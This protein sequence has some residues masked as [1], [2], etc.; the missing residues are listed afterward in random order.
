MRKRVG[1]PQPEVIWI[2]NNGKVIEESRKM[3]IEKT[4]LNTVLTINGI[5]S[6]DQGEFALKIKNRCGEDKYAIGIQVTDRPAPPGKPAVEDQNLDSVRLRWAAPTNDGGSPVRNYTVEMCTE[7]SK[8]WTKA[9][10][11]KQ[12]FITLF[13]LV[14]GENY[15]FRV[16]ADN[17]FGQSEPSEESEIVYV[18]DNSRVL[19]EPKKKEV[20]V[21]EQ[22]SV[23]YQ[24]ISKEAGPSEY[25]TIDIHRLPNDLQAKYIIHEELGKGAYGTVYRATERATGKTWAAKMV[26]VRPGVKKENVI[27]E[28]SMMNQLHHEKLLNLHEAFDMGNEMWLIEEFVS[29]GELFEKIL[30]DDSLM[31]EEEVR[32]YMHQILLGVSHMHKNQIVHLDLKPENILLK[33]KNSTDLKIIDFG[34]ARKLD[35]KKSVKLLFG[36]PEFCA[37][38]VVNYQP[39]GLSTD[40][41]T[42]GV[43]SYVLLSGLSPFL[44][45]SDE[46][47]LANVSAADWDFDDPSWDDV[48]DLA[49][50]FIC[51]LMIKDKRKRM[52]VQDALRHPWITGPLLSAF[53]DLSEYVKKMQP[54]PDKSGIPARQKRNFLSLKRW[55][56]DLLPIGRLA[57]R[58]AIFRRL[59]MDG[60]FERNIAFDT[61]AAP[62]VKKQL[63]DIVANVGDLI[64]TLSCDVDGVPSPKVQWYKDDKEL[65]VPSMKYDSFYNEGLAEL[66]VKNIVESDAGKY[67]CR[68]TNDLGSIMTHAK[69]SVKSDDKKK[70]KSETSPAVIE[71]KKDRKTSKVVVV[72]EMIDMPP[73]FHH[74]LQDDEA[75]IGEP[76]V[77]VVT[78]TTLPEPTVEWYHNGEHI[79]IQDSNYLQKHDKGRYELHIL[80]VDSTDEG[81][82]K[83]VGKNAFGECESEG[84]L[85]VVVPDGQ[86]APSFGRQLSDVKCSESDIL[87]LEVN[88]KANPAPEIN[89]FRNEAE[90][91][92]SQRHRLQFDDGSGNYSLTIIDA[93][94]EDSGEYKCV[95]KNKIGKAHTVCCVRIEELLA[96][97]SKKIDG[98]KAPR[99]RMQLPTPREVPQGS[100]LTLVCSVSGTPHP[101]IRWTKDD[102]PIDM[103]NK[104]VRHENGV[105]TLH[106]IGARDEDQG[107]YVC[108]AENIHG[109]AQS[110]SV[111]EIKEAVDKDHIKPK[112]LEPLVNCSTCEGNEIV[113]ECCVTGKPI[114]AITWYKDGLKLIIENRMLQYTDRKGVSRLNIMNVVMDDAG[115]YTCEAVNTL[116]KD[117]THCTVK[118]VDMGLAKTRLTPVRSRSRS[119]SR[120]P[121]VLGG[122]I[123][124]PPVVTRPLADATVTEGNRELLEVEVDGFPTPTIEWYH[125]GKL[126]AESRTLRTYFDGRVA[127][128]KIYEAH[129]EHNGQYVCKVSNKLGAVET[130]ACVVVEGPHA[131]EHVTQMPTFVKK[132]QD[133]V[134]KSAGET[135][136][137][138]CQ[139]YANPAAQVVWLHNGKALQQTNGNYKTRLFDDNTATLVIENVTDELC[140]T[141]TAV[142]TNQFGDVH[143]SAQLTIT[144]SEARKVA[145]SLP[146]F[147]IEPKPKINVNEGATLSIQADLNGS[148]TPEVVWLKDNSELVESER[149]QI[150]CDGV[151]YQLVV[152]GVG[153]EDEGTYTITAENEKGKVRQNTE[154][155]VT[156]S[157]DV[158]EKKEKKKVEKKDEDKKKPGRPGLPRPSGA[159]KT[160]QVTIAFDAPSEGPADSYEVERRCPDQREWTK[161]GTSKSLELEVKSLTPNTEYIFRVA[162]RNK[163]GLGEWAEMMTT[164]KTAPSGQAPQFSILPQSKM[165]IS[166]D[167]ELEISVEFSGN[168]TPSVKWYKENVQVVPDDKINIA[169]TSTSSTLQSKSQ[170]ENGTYTCFIENELGQASASCQVT[171][172][173]REPSHQST[174]DH[175]LERNLV[176]VVQKQLNNESAQA[177]QQIMLTCRISSRSG[178]T[179]AWFN[180]DERIES[181]G[182]FE[183][184]SDK[185]SN[186]KLVCHAVQYNDAGKYRCVVTN[187]YGYAESE[188]NVT[189]EDITKFIAPSFSSTLSDST[190]ILG[191]NITL[192][193]KVEGFPTPEISWTK[194]GER[195][196][197]T[198]RIRQIQDEN[199]NCKLIISKAESDDTGVYVCS[200]TS[201]SGV[202]STSSMVMIAKTTGTDSH[203]VIAQSIDDKQEKPRFIRAPPSLIEVNESGQFTLVAKAIGEPKPTVTWLKDGR[204]ILRTNR[205]YHHFVTGDGESHLIAECVVSKTSGIFSCKAENPHGTVIA[206]TQVIVQKMKPASDLANVAPKFTIPLTDMGIVNGHPTTL[207]CNVTGSPE[208]TLEWIYIDDSGNKT[209]LTS[210]TTSWTECR[211]GKVAEL[212]SE[213]VL[214][215]Q[216]G[217]YQCVATNSSGK[218]TTQC[219]LLVGELSDEPAGPPRFVKCLQDTWTPLKESIEF[220]VELAGFPTPDLTWYHNE[221]KIIEGKDV[222][223]T[224][225]S[226]TTSVL[227]IKNVSLASLG[228][229]YVEASNIHGV[230]RNAGRLN[231]SDE[232]RK[233]EPPQ[234]KHVLEPVLAVQPK[235]AFSE[236]HP[237]A[238]SS[239][240]TA[241][242]K[243]GAAP[244][245]LQGLEDMDLK[246]GASAAVA[247]KLGRKL[248]PHRSTTNDAD[249]LAKALAQSLKLEEPRHLMESRLESA[250]NTALDEVRAAINSRNKRVCRPKFMVK[251]KPKKVL[252]EY[253]SLRL[254]TAIS[255]NPM[256]QVHWD[257][258]GIILET[259]NKYSIYNDGD[260]YYLEVHHVST[261]DKGFYNCTA[262]NNEGIITCT[263]EIDVLPNKADSAAQVAKRR[264]RKEAKAPNFIEVLPGRSQANLNEYLCVECSV[265]AY[266]C[267]SIIWTRNSVRLLP[268]ADRYTMS[269]DGECASLKFISVAPGDEGTYSCEAVNEHGTAVSNMNLL[270]SGMDPNAAEGIPPLFRFEKIKSVKK[271]VDGSRVELA[272]ELV[273]AS[274]PLQI[275]WLRNKVTIVDSPS[276]SYS[277]SEKMVFLTIADVFPEDGGEYTVEAKNQSGIAR[278]TMQLDVRSNERSIADEAPRVFDFE[279]TTRTD[280][281]TSVELRAKIIGHP[282]PVITWTKANQK[283]NNEE[284]YLMRNE[285]DT[286]IL[287]ISNVTRADAGKYVLTAINASGQ[288][289]AE[290]ELTVIQSTKTVGEKPKFNE[291]PISVQTCEKNRAELRASFSGTP[292]PTCRWFYSGNELIDGLDGYTISVSE[293]DSSLLINSVDKKHFGEYLCTIRNQNGEELAN[294]MI[295]SEGSSAALPQQR[296]IR[297]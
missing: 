14:P 147:I 281:G 142:A 229:Y 222:K 4:A 254:K 54:K 20:K 22:E 88:I 59:T 38:E 45:D 266:P 165:I 246:A 172:F 30:E 118:V 12:A 49:K 72:E 110:F 48:S 166:R 7:K 140:G 36:T 109:V 158:K 119:R 228:M 247:G 237:R 25:K 163:Q 180:G 78:N 213:R 124:R 210:S 115:E 278:C 170:E 285:G 169:A 250:A 6:Q 198:R 193:C 122:D 56:D 268:Q 96:K 212:K 255:G 239:A 135:A 179:I 175:S 28:I 279:Q 83:A 70:K 11:T 104:Q 132:L 154:V 131:A 61:D 64:A 291:S 35:P 252:E 73:N 157:K 37:P 178:S 296:T 34:L 75:K 197:T 262:A 121:S 123:Q 259:G 216:R 200:A 223:I 51:R 297:R 29:G 263:S 93:Y 5:D 287:R 267:A 141:Y 234:F 256:P 53:N 125:D 17:T 189:V 273:Q 226:D 269:Y 120:S 87:K 270:V 85:T 39:V 145:A 199:G 284:R 81:K 272:A 130:R 42:V 161:C 13:N 97:R 84:K 173:N 162:G 94:A 238:S 185:K 10:V 18:K 195:I 21:K 26:Q 146:Y 91:E 167:D 240:A 293:T 249:K 19:E 2:D 105:C 290:L 184:S 40:M 233:A 271:V 80:S 62:S 275:R 174:P 102:Q 245:F 230:L 77:L 43:I 41:W 289:N 50:D 260:F 221:K 44:G 68:A 9:E 151:S 33:A 155:S 63:E 277:R 208:P 224:F 187:K 138:T 116:G 52:S 274:E 111:V 192:E 27:H 286:F 66:T 1:R 57:K 253:K 248:R 23:D 31:S 144:G 47:T 264:S 76:K 188:C 207:S 156:K 183:L 244:M 196:S 32:D 241:R 129:E 71:K 133:V 176:P 236:E 108:E 242:V 3:K 164:L 280:P 288:A 95:A 201:V 82:W 258:E 282:D 235:V 101:N 194:D 79:S 204:E 58:G 128:L 209:N 261:F 186:H 148:P 65:T 232:R 100:D 276:F 168:P 295:L 55:S 214:R 292:A 46:D 190:A 181:A 60:V 159:S 106:I 86:F 16:R 15:T 243:K 177:G 98:S 283:L 8:T 143:T 153:L 107:R 171:V 220:S 137:F 114:P 182:R 227:S 218:A 152:R 202:D 219:Y 191:H 149:I 90:I 251:P 24:K 206:E 113:L 136:T 215:E 150:K 127:F 74:L 89:W 217:T 103:S 231:V 257:K 117:F 211:F 134:L 160:D 203:L 67:T 99:F 112:F 225:P 69:L 92:H 294:A 205:I 126:V 139:S 265:S